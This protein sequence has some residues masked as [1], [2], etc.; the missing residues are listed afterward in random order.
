[1]LSSSGR[2]RPLPAFDCCLAEQMDTVTRYRPVA[3]K[4]LDLVREH[5]GADQG[6]RQVPLAISPD[7]SSF[8]AASSPVPCLLRQP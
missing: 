5:R 7:K 1:M 8:K 2:Q 4:K 3:Q 6:N